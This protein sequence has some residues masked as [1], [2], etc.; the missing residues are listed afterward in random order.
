MVD[1]KNASQCQTDKLAQMAARATWQF[2]AKAL[3]CKQ[4][5]PEMLQMLQLQLRE[6]CN[7]NGVRNSCIISV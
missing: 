3:A 7:C 5:L 2:W 1:R 4:L 6:I